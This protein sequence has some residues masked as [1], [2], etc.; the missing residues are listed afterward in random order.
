MRARCDALVRDILI[1]KERRDLVLRDPCAIH[2]ELFA[3]LTPDGYPEYAGTYR[4][5]PGTTLEGREISGPSLL[6]PGKTFLFTSS[7]H[8]PDKMAE[9]VDYVSWAIASTPENADQRLGSLA[10]TFGLFGCIH[11]FL[12]GNG[13][14]QR[15]IFAA[16]ATAFGIPLSGRFSIHP[17]PYDMLLMTML[18]LFTRNSG[19]QDDI[20]RVGEYLRFFL[21]GVYALPYEDFDSGG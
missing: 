13:H 8:V 14:V 9:L 16:M 15:V 12:D 11:P 19:G 2:R 6:A 21:D 17:R 20:N 4:G 18:E 7:T 1:N 3:S 10:K 5:Q